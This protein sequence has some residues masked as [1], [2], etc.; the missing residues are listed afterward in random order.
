M[1]LL[2]NDLLHFG[3]KMEALKTILVEHMGRKMKN[4]FKK[5]AQSI[6]KMRFRSK[7]NFFSLNTIEKSKPIFS[8]G[9]HHTIFET[10]VY[11]ASRCS[12]AYFEFGRSINRCA[13]HFSYV[14]MNRKSHLFMRAFIYE[15]VQ[16]LGF[17]A[18]DESSS[19]PNIHTE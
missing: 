6:I 3:G 19:Q 17:H 13:K 12:R 14:Y 2:I 4:T 5:I 15:I 8:V 11:C 9:A 10:A 18:M 16:H 1:A 7:L